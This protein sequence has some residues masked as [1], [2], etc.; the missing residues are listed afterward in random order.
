MSH[1][2]VVNLAPETRDEHPVV[3]V[4]VVLRFSAEGF[5]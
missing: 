4:F 3:F 1:G 5:N 2:V